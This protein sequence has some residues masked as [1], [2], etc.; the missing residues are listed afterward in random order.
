MALARAGLVL[1][2]VALL[3][4][5]CFVVPAPPPPGP[6]LR[7]PPPPYVA[8]TPDCGWQYGVGWYGWGWYGFGCW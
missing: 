4:G 5:G 2:L 1:A 8:A 3:L 6:G 7:P